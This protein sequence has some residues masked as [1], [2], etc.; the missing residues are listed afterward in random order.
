[1]MIVKIPNFDHRY[2]TYWSHKCQ[3]TTLFIGQR[4]VAEAEGDI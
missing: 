2:I 3:N 1:M 4:D